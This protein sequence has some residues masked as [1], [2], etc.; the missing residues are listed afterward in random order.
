MGIYILSILSTKL[1]FIS[2][3]EI[4]VRCIYFSSQLDNHDCLIIG[5]LI[6]H[7]R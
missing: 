5:I 4:L 3:Y 6:L 7:S 1:F 2:L